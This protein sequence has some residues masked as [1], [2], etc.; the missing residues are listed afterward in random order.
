M[1]FVAELSNK[2]SLVASSLDY[3]IDFLSSVPSGLP[4]SEMA[5]YLYI[6]WCFMFYGILFCNVNSATVPCNSQASRV[7]ATNIDLLSQCPAGKACSTYSLRRPRH[8]PFP[9]HP[10]IS[11]GLH[12]SNAHHTQGWAYGR[13]RH[14]Y[15]VRTLSAPP[16]LY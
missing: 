4:A 12:S 2:C 1:S 16:G 5:P 8:R 6:Y 13:L 10:P 9:S 3:Q 14:R 7:L 11:R 15:N